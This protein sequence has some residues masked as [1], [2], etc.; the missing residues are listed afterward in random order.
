MT[1]LLLKKQA[2]EWPTGRKPVS[3]WH[4]HCVTKGTTYLYNMLSLNTP[5]L[6]VI[7]NPHVK[8]MKNK[9]RKVFPRMWTL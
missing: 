6:K 9:V 3:S 8:M 7:P 1:T 5:L 2:M 4:P